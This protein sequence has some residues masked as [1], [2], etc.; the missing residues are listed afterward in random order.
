MGVDS[1]L[2]VEK[3]AGF[4]DVFLSDE[5]RDSLALYRGWLETEGMKAGGIGP[6]ERNRLWDRHIADSMVLGIGLSGGTECL[7]I[8]SGAGLPGI[9]LA[10]CFPDIEFTLLDRS[11]RRCDLMRRAIAVLA[12]DNCGVVEDDVSG[13]SERYERIVSRAAMSPKSMMIH[14]KRL[15]A[16]GGVA[17]LGISRDTDKATDS[18]DI[19]AGL[20]TEVIKVPDEVLDSGAFLLRIEAT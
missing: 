13:V 15:L 7:D 11:G 1:F 16:S 3:A 5:Q 17:V 4:L 18:L 19:V 8:G 6:A 2:S 20:V 10:I 12:L 14:V 9:P